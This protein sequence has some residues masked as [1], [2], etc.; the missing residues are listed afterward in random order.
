MGRGFEGTF[1]QLEKCHATTPLLPAL[2]LELS[3][4]ESVPVIFFQAVNSFCVW[5]RSSVSNLSCYQFSS[6]QPFITHTQCW[7]PEEQPPALVAGPLDLS[8]SVCLLL[9]HRF[10]SSLS[11]AVLPTHWLTYLLPICELLLLLYLLH[12]LESRSS[13]C[14]SLYYS[15]LPSMSVSCLICLLVICAG[16]PSKETPLL[17]ISPSSSLT[18]V[19]TIF[20]SLFFTSDNVQEVIL[21]SS[22][23]RVFLMD[24]AY[25]VSVSLPPT[26]K[27]VLQGQQH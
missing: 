4:P 15:L 7:L 21:T 25:R 13:T 14:C 12:P 23:S 17:H 22:E 2:V 20:L 27:T 11:F 5:L 26:N 19:F 16:N 9:F 24:Q 18:H 8:I 6:D 1:T 10:I 3:R